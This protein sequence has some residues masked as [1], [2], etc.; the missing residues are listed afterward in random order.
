MT[1]ICVRYSCFWDLATKACVPIACFFVGCTGD[2]DSS[3]R[4]NPSAPVL[5]ADR[6]ANDVEQSQSAGSLLGEK[7][8]RTLRE[9]RFFVFF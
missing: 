7:K 8:I 3:A 4:G 1:Y 5:S 9:R 6:C 2:P